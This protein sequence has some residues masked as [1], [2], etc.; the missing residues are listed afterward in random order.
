MKV[1]DQAAILHNGIIYKSKRHKDIAIENPHIRKNGTEGFATIHG[2]FIDRETAANIAYMSGQ[3]TK[4][5][6]ELKSEHLY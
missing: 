3:I 1:I 4:P 2:M 5:V 6:K